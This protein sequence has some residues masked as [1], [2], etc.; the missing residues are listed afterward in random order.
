VFWTTASCLT[1]M[2]PVFKN[3][4]NYSDQKPIFMWSIILL[5][6]RAC[7]GRLCTG[8]RSLRCGA[9]LCHAPSSYP[10]WRRFAVLQVDDVVHLALVWSLLRYWCEMQREA[11][12]ARRA[13]TAVPL[14]VI[15]AHAAAGD[16]AGDGEASAKK[17]KKKKKKKRSGDDAQPSFDDVGGEAAEQLAGDDGERPQAAGV[18]GDADEGK[19]EDEAE[20]PS[21]PLRPGGSGGGASSSPRPRGSPP[22]PSAAAA[23]DVPPRRGSNAGAASA[24]SPASVSRGAGT[25]GLAPP[26]L[27]QTVAPVAAPFVGEIPPMILHTLTPEKFEDLWA[28]ME[29]SGSFECTVSQVCIAMTLRDIGTCRARPQS[30][31]P[32]HADAVSRCRCRRSLPS[33]RTCS[34]AGSRPWHLDSWTAC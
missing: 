2:G 15:A 23:P 24:G 21:S 14:S 26:P 8:C 7:I 19:S 11:K 1:A 30:P 3:D 9:A 20:T 29:D 28:R 34:H 33:S 4:T 25:A 18:D 22:P 6:V 16:A 31:T 17:K 32:R 5:V 13:G 12:P 10:P 27:P